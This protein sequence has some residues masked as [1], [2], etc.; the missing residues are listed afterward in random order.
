MG[1]VSLPGSDAPRMT[2]IQIDSVMFIIHT[3]QMIYKW[4]CC[5]CCWESS[6]VGCC[7]GQVALYSW[8]LIG[9]QPIGTAN[10][11]WPKW[12]QS[13]WSDMIGLDAKGALSHK[14]YNDITPSYNFRTIFLTVLS[15][16]ERTEPLKLLSPSPPLLPGAVRGLP[17]SP[18]SHF[19]DALPPEWPRSLVKVS[20]VPFSGK[21]G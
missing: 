7:C 21:R 20:P 8:Q 18:P 9:P 4:T 2:R 5:F 19:I 13:E 16:V 11:L 12:N 6:A 1:G 17:L 14:W 3:S 10:W 15:E